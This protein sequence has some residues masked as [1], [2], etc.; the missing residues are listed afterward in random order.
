MRGQ[1]SKYLDLQSTTVDS[2]QTSLSIVEKS[3]DLRV[4]VE[5]RE[6]AG[7]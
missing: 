6:R 3:F 5:L 2:Y 1:S 4:R 7:I